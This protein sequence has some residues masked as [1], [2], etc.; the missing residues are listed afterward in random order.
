VTHDVLP[1]GYINM[2]VSQSKDESGKNEN[3]LCGAVTKNAA[4]LSGHV[5]GCL[6]HLGHDDIYSRSPD[7]AHR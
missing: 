3:E 2:E 5:N 6:V 7:A 1:L 4:C